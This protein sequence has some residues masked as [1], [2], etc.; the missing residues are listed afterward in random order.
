M[1]EMPKNVERVK[2]VHSFETGRRWLDGVAADHTGS[3]A[4]EKMYARALQRFCEYLGKTPDQLIAERKEELKSD[5]EKI[6]RK[7]EEALKS[8]C[9]H[10]RKQGITSVQYHASIRSFYKYNYYPLVIRTPPEIFDVIPPITM[11]EFRLIDA[12]AGVRYRAHIRFLKDSGMS[13][14][15][16]VKITYGHIRKEIE[17]G[18]S[19]I[20]LYVKRQ[21]EKIRY[22]T[23]LGPN[24]V[25]AL[26]V[27]FTTR[28]NRGEEITD[29]TRI[30]ASIKGKPISA[31]TLSVELRRLGKKVGITL[32]P[33]RLRKLFETYMAVGGVHPI[34]LKYWMGHKVRGS[35]IEAKYIIPPEPKQRELY[36]EGYKNIEIAPRPEIDELQIKWVLLKER[37][38]LLGHDPMLIFKRKKKERAPIRE[39]VKLLEREL[40]RL[41]GLSLRRV[42]RKE[43]TKPNGGNCNSHA[44]ITEEQLLSYLDDGWEIVRELSNGN[45]V[46][47]RVTV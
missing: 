4:T 33:H 6:K 16:A 17:A 28:R 44:I 30:F 41:E 3:E 22:E 14:E 35:D 9:L 37:A 1:R 38:R 20:H 15:D 25:E 23:Y 39:Q 46:V 42:K 8:F 31:D 29:D 2:W 18:K 12:A 11:E 34:I 19:F 24:A 5:E 26:K 36:M 21:K 47:R 13:R 10:L 27:L 40:P 7:A 32:S 43:R 45:I